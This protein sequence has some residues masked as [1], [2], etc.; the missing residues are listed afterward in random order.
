[1]PI[2]RCTAVI[3][4][5][6]M[7]SLT[8]CYSK[9]MRHLASDAG[10]IT[11]GVSG[12]NDVLTYLG[13]PDKQ[14]KRDGGIEEW[15]YIEEKISTMQRMPLLGYFFSGGGYEKITVIFRNRIVESCQYREFDEDE[16]EW[17]DDYSWQ[18]IEE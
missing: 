3:V 8:G 13:E 5:C 11:V 12:R 14:R 9:S 17:A 16:L 10:L 15:V 7:L 18:E 4:I 1:M 6:V 2:T